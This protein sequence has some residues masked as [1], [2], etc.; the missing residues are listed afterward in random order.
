MLRILAVSMLYKFGGREQF[1]VQVSEDEQKAVMI[2]R[3]FTDGRVIPLREQ[4]YTLVSVTS[5]VEKFNA[6]YY[7]QEPVEIEDINDLPNYLGKFEI[8]R[9]GYC[10]YNPEL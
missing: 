10:R 5:A 9:P 2:Y 3:V 7:V 1:Y 6:G 8:L 4:L